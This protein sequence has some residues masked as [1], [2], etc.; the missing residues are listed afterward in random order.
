[1]SQKLNIELRRDIALALQDYREWVAGGAIAGGGFT[2]AFGLCKNLTQYSSIRRTWYGDDITL[3]LSEMFREDGLCEITPF[4]PD[5]GSY[6]RDSA[7]RAHHKNVA[8][9]AWVNAVI[10]KYREDA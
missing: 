3:E 1:M 5:E 8:R 2:S 6:S 10:E 4:N 9:L 7:N